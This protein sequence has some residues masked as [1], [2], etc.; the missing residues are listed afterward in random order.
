MAKTRKLGEADGLD[1]R[2]KW[3]KERYKVRFG[4]VVM[5]RQGPFT[6]DLEL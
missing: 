3:G 5:E 4:Q 6:Q 1:L 2:R